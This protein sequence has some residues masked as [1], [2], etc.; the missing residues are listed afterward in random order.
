MLATGSPR[1]RSATTGG[2]LGAERIS[3]DGVRPAPAR[4]P[5]RVSDGTAT[6]E[7]RA[8]TAIVIGA[9]R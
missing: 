2:T 5:V 7:M 8:H 6:V 4:A 1:G 3:A 9:S